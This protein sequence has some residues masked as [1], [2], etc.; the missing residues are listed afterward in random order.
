MLGWLGKYLVSSP[1]LLPLAFC[2]T[3]LVNAGLTRSNSFWAD[4]IKGIVGII[5]TNVLP[6]LDEEVL[7]LYEQVEKA[8][9]A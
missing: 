5:G 2:T 6:F 1:F 3:S 7:E 4:P 8:A 9:Y